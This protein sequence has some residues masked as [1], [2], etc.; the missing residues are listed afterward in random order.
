MI[1]IVFVSLGQCNLEWFYVLSSWVRTDHTAR[2]FSDLC[3][4]KLKEM[5][6]TSFLGYFIWTL[7]SIQTAAS[8]YNA[9]PVWMEISTWSIMPLGHY[10]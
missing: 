8:H 1:L 5:S 7:I 6:N 4:N 9:K 2:Y 10:E 3:H